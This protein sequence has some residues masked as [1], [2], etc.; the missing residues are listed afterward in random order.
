MKSFLAMQ[1]P[2]CKHR[3][4]E[5]MDKRN[6]VTIIRRRRRCLSCQHRFTTHEYVRADYWGSKPV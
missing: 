6:T 2:K 5:V 3:E 4:S 1:C